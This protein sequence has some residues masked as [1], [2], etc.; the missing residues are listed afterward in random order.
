[1]KTI[2][3]KLFCLFLLL[4]LSM[5][6]QNTITGTVTDMLS[7]QPISGANVMVQ[8]GKST[9]TGFD[10]GFQLSNVKNG[11]KITVSFIG[12]K[13]K[14]VIYEGQK[15]LNVAIA[16]DANALKE[17]VI[18]VGY[19]V[20]K[21]KD[22]TG[23]VTVLTAKDF[24]KG[25]LV[26]VDQLLTGKSAGVRITN[27]GGEPD[28]APNIRIRGG[29]SIS[30]QNSP[31]IVIDGVPLDLVNAAGNQNPL[32][33]VNPNDIDS[34]SILKDASATAIYGSRASNGVIIITTKKGKSG[35]PEFNFSTNVAIG[36]IQKQIAVK[37]GEEFTSFIQNKFP[38]YTYLLGV[39]DPK[40]PKI[41]DVTEDKSETTGVEGRILS[42]TNWVDL[43]YRQSITVDNNF[44]ARG[45]LFNKVPFRASVG[46]T[47]NQG[48]VRTNEFER[49][50]ASLKLTPTLLQDHLKIDVNAKG[51]FSNKN[52]I[53]ATGVFGSA[54]NYD[55]T[56]PA[57]NADGSFYQ[58]FSGGNLVGGTNPLAI[59]EQRKR[60]EKIRKFLG[61]A[62]F[63]YKLHFFPQL[64]AVVNLGLEASTSSIEETYIGN[65]F[66][67][68]QSITKVYNAGL[69][70]KEDQTITNKTLDAYIVYTKEMTGF[71]KKVDL[72]GGYTYQNFANDGN[73]KT[74]RYNATTGL[75]EEILNDP[76]NKYYNP[77]NL[78]SFFGRSNIDLAGKYLFTISFRADASSLFLKDKRWG[79]FPAAAFAWKISD[80]ALFKDSKFISSLKLRLGA[81]KTGQQD[82]TGS[83]GYFPTQPLFS[84]G[85][86]TAQYLPGFNTYAALPFDPNITW[87][88][89]TTYNAG[90]DF[91]L[92][93]NRII[94]GSVDLYT[95]KTTDLLAVVPI[96]PG[97]GLTNE[98][99]KNV[100]DTESKG[101][102]TNLTIKVASTTNFNLDLNGNVGYNYTKVTN[103]GDVTSV[104]ATE[105]TIPNGTGTRIAKHAVGFQPYSA[106]VFEQI[107]NADGKPIEGAFVDRNRDGAITDSDRY[108]KAI[109]PN[110]T[111]GFGL[112]AN[113][114]NIDF[115]TSFRGQQGGLVYNTK[116]LIAG[117]VNHAAP[118]Q[119]NSLNNVLSGDLL[120]NNNIGNQP[121]SDYFFQ[122]A[123]FI[124]C[125]NVVL[126]YKFT[127]AVKNGSIRV[128]LSANNLFLI[129]KYK[130][131]DPENFNGIDNNFY[132][133]PRVYSF[134]LNLNF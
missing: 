3:K 83:V 6:A 27:N 77:L 29:S 86:T 118:G 114:K 35:K 24:N 65:A 102:E 47:N 60:P 7:K 127:K 133:R 15:T 88:K 17:V 16:E 113:Y 49:V 38:G 51:S 103:L 8:G 30:G 109:R 72:Q 11:D 55:P 32:S 84:A 5:L 82:V 94:S 20:V 61:N 4:P 10:G 90:I 92:F 120:F 122:D 28:S 131:Q 106:Y 110:W 111:F 45:S 36:S 100:G 59:L 130:G 34:F 73:K 91:D 115:S 123:T 52:A 112:S 74:F 76:T 101:F 56:K 80:E 57:Y 13:S 95:R 69:N 40:T 121:L 70:Y 37:G 42:N 48:L 71:L 18:Q 89:T 81:G 23:A 132:P 134:G 105:S 117:N 97:Q 126:G 44:S 31:L 96:A 53:D 124:R 1:M 12:Y 58:E 108:Y 99:I 62:E 46:H 79:Y 33:L 2:Y 75:R 116:E 125:E 119:V 19:G 68:Y 63:D 93:K 39:D 66:Q 41:N 129:T 78:Q 64:R 21:K 107:Y 98:F 87:E 85:S 25:S 50:T 104:S 43:I 67:T 9:A 14:D 26:S 22:A 128:Y 54:L